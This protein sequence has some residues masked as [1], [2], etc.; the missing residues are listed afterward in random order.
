MTSQ[1][2]DRIADVMLYEGYVLY[3]YRPSVKNRQRWTFGGLVPRSYSEAHAGS[4]AWRMHTEC[5]VRGD[6]GTTLTVRA[7][8]LHLQARR[9]WELDRPQTEVN[10]TE[11]PVCHAVESL[12]V[13][14]RVH[15]AWQEASERQFAPEA[16][17]LG[18]LAARPWRGAFLFPEG[19]RREIVRESAGDVVALIVRE[20]DAVAGQ[21]EVSAEKVAPDVFKVR[22][23][24]ENHAVL[25]DAGAR[26]RDDALMRSLVSSHVILSV[27]GGDF[28]SCFDP[29]EE[30]RDAAAACQHIGVW[31]VLVGKP[32]A[33]DTMLAAPIILYD[34]PRVAD[35][36]PG[37]L[38]DCT[39]I[40][41]ILTLRIQTLTDEEKQQAAGV[42]DRVRAL[43]ER[44]GALAQDQ[45]RGLHGTMRGLRAVPDGEP[46]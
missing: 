13:G 33:T 15:H 39:E 7:R 32:G 1:L 22:V 23:T 45:L 31:P 18:D 8:F 20:Q 17:T 41:E 28:I 25:D 5:L 46:T 38:F 37:D 34:Y 9:V 21:L 14:E 43:V 30:L 12:K 40:D 42:D 24:V 16:W 2:V 35:E 10:D 11:E 36:S 26:L 27:R 19:R 4:D 6:E 3:P 44:T 29:P